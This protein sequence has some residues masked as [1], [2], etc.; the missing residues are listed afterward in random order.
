VSESGGGPPATARSIT[1]LNST[2][3]AAVTT[4]GY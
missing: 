3:P 2:W 1:M 4:A